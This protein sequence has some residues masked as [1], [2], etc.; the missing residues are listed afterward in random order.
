MCNLIAAGYE[1]IKSYDKAI[2]Y[3]KEAI[4]YNSSFH[5]AYFNLGCIYKF[6]NNY[7]KAIEEFKNV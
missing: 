1:G 7:L 3:L 4:K 6:N 2:E 5:I